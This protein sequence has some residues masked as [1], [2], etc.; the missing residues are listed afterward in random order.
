M[1]DFLYKP[2]CLLHPFP[3]HASRGLRTD[4]PGCRPCMGRYHATLMQ[5]VRIS[6]VQIS[7]IPK[8]WDMMGP[9][10]EN[11]ANKRTRLRVCLTECIQQIEI[12]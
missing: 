11:N 2:P 1:V 7:N 4:A 10:L 3:S 6:V 9:G 5:D 12:T 8:S